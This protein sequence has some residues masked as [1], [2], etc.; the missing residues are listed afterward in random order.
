MDEEAVYQKLDDRCKKAI[1]GLKLKETGVWLNSAGP[2][3]QSIS[4]RPDGLPSIA[5]AHFNGKHYEAT[6]E[7]HQLYV[8]K[9]SIFLTHIRHLELIVYFIQRM[10]I[11]EL[12][13]YLDDIF[14]QN[15]TK[16]EF[17]ASLAD[18]FERIKSNGNNYLAA[19]SG[20][21]K[22]CNFGKAGVAFVG[23][24]DG[25][26]FDIIFKE[27]DKRVSDIFECNL[28]ECASP[29]ANVVDKRI[30]FKQ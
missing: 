3:Y 2:L 4:I 9:E 29:E 21:C 23:N 17:I 1:E 18:V 19:R 22:G 16:N 27:V 26:Y 14:Y 6:S 12:N 25:S 7:F 8:Q 5:N 10:N 30:V 11:Y 15:K 24:V 28:F 20:T 13:H